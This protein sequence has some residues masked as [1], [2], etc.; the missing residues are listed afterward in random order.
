MEVSMLR[1]LMD[2]GF[3]DDHRG[4]KCPDRLFSS[5]NRKIKQTI[6][7]AMDHYNRSVTPDEVQ[8]LFV[9][10]NPTMTTA[11]RQASTASL[12]NSS[13]RSRWATTSHRRCCPS[14]FRR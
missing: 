5:D 9:S 4:A 10:G 1:S 2:K 11:Q 12:P 14:C 3:Y 6:D 8:A 13:V 7:K